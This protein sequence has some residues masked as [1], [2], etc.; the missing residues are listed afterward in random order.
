MEAAALILPLD[1]PHAWVK[2]GHV[3]PGRAFRPAG[4]PHAVVGSCRGRRPGSSGPGPAGVID[5]VVREQRPVQF[6][7]VAL[8]PVTHAA[9]GAEQTPHR[10]SSVDSVGSARQITPHDREGGHALKSPSSPTVNGRTGNGVEEIVRIAAGGTAT[11]GLAISD[12]RRVEADS[13]GR[14]GGRALHVEAGSKSS[15]GGVVVPLAPARRECERVRVPPA[16]RL[17][18]SLVPAVSTALGQR[19]LSAVETSTSVPIVVVVLLS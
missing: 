2:L 3:Q 12:A 11:P 18:R 19:L 17:P 7:L 6:V 10:A 14:L 8:L 15:P 5:G 1:A 13:S 16:V 9:P 4:R